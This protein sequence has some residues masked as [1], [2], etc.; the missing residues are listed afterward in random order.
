MSTGALSSLPSVDRLLNHPLGSRLIEAHGREPLK[1]SL[2]RVLDDCRNASPPATPDEA[3][4]L[5]RAGELL[6][7]SGAPSLRTVYNLT[8]TVIHTNLGRAPLP[9]SAIE[10]MAEVASGA[11]NLE[12]DLE[13]GRRGDRD[14]HIE[15][16][17][18]EITGAEAATIVNNNAAAVLLTLNTF[19]EGR[20][21]IVSRGELV[22]I[23][24]SFRI[25]EIMQRAGC[26][27]R[28]VGATNR[29]HGRDFKAAISERTGL[30]MKVH[31]SNYEIRGFTHAVA[32][33][34]LAAIAG[35]AGIP[36]VNDLG[37]GTLADLTRYGLP[38]EPTVQ[39]ALADGAGLVT[40]SGD[41]LLGGPQAGM[42]V[43]KRELVE[44]I[45]AN[46]MKRALRVDK[47]T[48]AAMFE[49]LKLY[50]DPDSLIQH[51]PTLRLLA[52]SPEDIRDTAAS[53]QPALA[54]AFDGIASVTTEPCNAQIGSGALP[55][56]VLPGYAC[57]ITPTVAGDSMVQAISRAL[58]QLPRPVICR[59]SDGRL[60]LDMR[61]VE[62][63]APLIDQ[64]SRLRLP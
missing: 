4:I 23:G 36:L 60:W 17:L 46:P 40:F 41:K 2:R 58:R 45:K 18:S 13:T 34:E 7:A 47:L 12:Y 61:T 38:P 37:S 28:E 6:D 43:G 42:I 51:L 5:G 63:A 35:K 31:T 44:R 48:L 16:L 52:R 59:V 24:G 50:R 8:G 64:L 26:S 21:V 33:R 32:E 25:P 14:V 22:E 62:D 39:A 10:R 19:A 20:E 9:T 56:E 27:L 57:V 30:I 53:V 55:T 49:V 54:R 15:A 3:T 1:Q 11:S 29:T